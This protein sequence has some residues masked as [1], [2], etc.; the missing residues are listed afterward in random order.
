[1]KINE[2]NIPKSV[3]KSTAPIQKSDDFDKNSDEHRTN[4]RLALND[5]LEKKGW[6][7][8][9]DGAFSVVYENPKKSYVLKINVRP[10]PAFQHYVNLT[11]R[12]KNRHFPKISDVQEF[13]VGID[14]YYVYLIE[15]LYGGYNPAKEWIS[16]LN[17][18]HDGEIR[19]QTKKYFDKNK[20]LYRALM[21]IY[22]NIKPFHLDLHYDN[23]LKRKD[24]T[25]VISDPYS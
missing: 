1:M 21:L 18:E 25:T 5:I 9:G 16:R 10:D 7:P 20:E 12:F 13:K 3:V 23:I 2:L 15:K 17:Y 4:K 19:P 6:T 11:K 22:K 14:T 8:I 24:G